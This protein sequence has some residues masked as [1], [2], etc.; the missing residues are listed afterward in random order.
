MLSGNWE[1]ERDRAGGTGEHAAFE[2]NM[3]TAAHA[4]ES[5]APNTRRGFGR[6]H[7][8]SARRMARARSLDRNG[9]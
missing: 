8:P 5:M 7:S 9:L 1:V 2:R 6:A 3:L 4:A